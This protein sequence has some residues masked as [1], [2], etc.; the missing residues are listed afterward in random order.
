M[1]SKAYTKYAKALSF[2]RVMP[3]RDARLLIQYGRDLYRASLGREDAFYRD[4]GQY[5]ANFP[6]WIAACAAA[7]PAFVKFLMEDGKEIGLAVLGH[8]DRDP[9]VGR[10]HHFYMAP[11][12]RGQGFGGLLDDFARDVLTDAGVRVARLNVAARNDRAIRFYLA[13]GWG[14]KYRRGGLIFMETKL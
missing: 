7:N 13:Q 6:V 1:S 5:G 2:R 14:E 12:H 8:D 9:L 4:Y 10:V 3:E 11:S